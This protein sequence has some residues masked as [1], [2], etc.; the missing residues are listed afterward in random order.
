[1]SLTQSQL[2]L[3]FVLSPSLCDVEQYW[4]RAAIHN[5]RRCR[6]SPRAMNALSLMMNGI[7][8]VFLRVI[9]Y[10]SLVLVLAE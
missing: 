10:R 8:D 5:A 1:M 9:Q 7:D 4:W 2:Q 6:S 3:R